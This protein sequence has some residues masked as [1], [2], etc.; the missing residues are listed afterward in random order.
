MTGLPVPAGNKKAAEAGPQYSG[1]A[2][3]PVIGIGASAGGLEALNAF[4]AA[5]APNSGMAFVVVQHLDPT[6]ESL[7]AQLLRK[8]TTI[9]INLITDG[10]TVAPDQIYLIPPGS[11]LTIESRIFR[12]REPAEGGRVTLPFDLFLRSLAET[13]GD[14]CGCVILS[15]SG[16][17]G[18]L[19]ARAVKQQG[20]LVVAQTPE[21]ATFDAMP[22][23]VIATGL[24]DAVLPAKLIH[25]LVSAY[26]RQKTIRNRRPAEVF[27][28]ALGA[29]LGEV[30]NILRD[31]TGQDFHLYKT[32]TLLRRLDRRMALNNCNDPSAYLDLLRTREE[33][34][35]ALVADLLINVTS[36]FR[37]PPSFDWLSEKIIPG[38]LV[39]AEDKQ[40]IRVGWPDAAVEKRFTA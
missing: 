10:M 27:D 16:S 24:V 22:R 5:A 30:I 13:W 19:G 33:E 29:A 11:F 2:Q 38:L 14:C 34:P 31:K 6:H 18:T 36:F 25:G 20:G 39:R 26:F 3:F 40:T 23:S 12:L 17:D 7:M 1:E 28:P 32:A 37:D 35:A 15:G 8:R 4:F 21:E 9:G